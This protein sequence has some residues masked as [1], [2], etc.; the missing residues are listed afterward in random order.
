M[1]HG[2]QLATWR[3]V[4]ALG[5]RAIR[6]LPGGAGLLVLLLGSV[7][8]R[9]QQQRQ[10]PVLF[11]E[12]AAARSVAARSVL[13]ASLR[14]ARPLTID[15]MGVQAA[16]ATAPREGRGGAPLLFAL[17]LPDGSTGNFRVV[18][19]PVM[20]PGL[21]AQFPS[22]KTYSGVGVDDP[23]ASVR[24]DVTPRGFHAQVLSAHGTVYIDP[25]SQTD[26]QHYLSFYHKDMQR[27][28]F[29]CGVS[30]A[31]AAQRTAAGMASPV[32]RTVG[33]TLRTFRL[34]MAATGEYTAF[35][36]GTVALGQ[37]A[38][39]TTVNRV[40]GVYERELAVRMVLVANNSQL[41]YTNASTDP[42]SNTSSDLN[43]ITTSI[44]NVI[45]AANYDIGHLVGTG[46]GGV[47]GLGVV[48]GSSKGRGLTGSPS[49]VGDAF[50]IDYVAHEIGHQF[51]GNHTF[52]SPT[53]NCAGNR[54]ANTAYEPGSGST[55]MA[56]AGICGSDDL[57]PNSDPFFHVVSFEEISA[58]VSTVTC[59]T[60]TTTGNTPPVIASLPVSG[61]VIPISTPFKLTAGATDADGDALTYN[62]EEYDLGPSGT[63]TAAQVA[64]Q[65]PP[66]F[67]SFAPTT[68][69]TRYFPRLSNLLTNTLP[70][71][72]R[73]PTVTRNLNFRVTVRDN[74]KGVNSSSTV[75]MSTTNSAGPFVVLSPNAAVSWVSLSNQTVTW[76]VS[77]T[78]TAPVS[79]A[80]VNIR[81]STDGGLTYPTVLATNTQNDG[82]EVITV[83]NLATTT[84]R[85][86][87]EAADNYF[88][89][90][91]NTNFTITATAVPVAVTA[92]NRAGSNPSN[93]AVVGFTVTFSGNVTGLS[94]ANFALAT[95][96]GVSGASISSVSGSGASYVVAVNTGTGSGTLGL[97]LSNSAGL[98]PS[99]STPLPFVGQTYIIDKA[100]PVVT[101]VAVPA[102]GTYTTGQALDFL[103]NF[104]EAAFVTTSGGL[105]T[106]GV[107]VGAT[108]RQTQYVSGSG[109]TALTFRYTV[110]AGE[111]DTDGIAVGTLA[112][113]GGT[114]RDA[115][116]NDA[117]L[118]LA[119][120]AATAGVLV[121][122]VNPSVTIS[123]PASPTTATSPIPFSV[124]FS[125]PVT[126]FVATDVSVTNGTVSS[127]G[128]TGSSYT[129][130]VTPTA[131]GPVTVS[132]AAGVAQDAAGNGNSA[133]TPVTRVYAPVATVANVRVL[134]QNDEPG[135]PGN[136][137]VRPNLQL[138]NDGTA[139]IPYA[140]LTMRYWLT[141]ENFAALTTS[142]NWA[143]LGT[144]L[145][146]ARYVPLAA[147]LQGAMG[148]VEYS[149]LPGAG[150]LLPNTGSGPILSSFN[151]SNWTNFDETDDYSYAPNS[152][153]QPTTRITVYR[154]GTLIGGVEP[155][156]PAP[157]SLKVYA[158]NQTTSASAQVITT[159]AQIGNLSGL[160][161]SYAGLTV[162]YWFTPDGPSP[163]VGNVDYAQLGS[164][165]I[166]LTIGQQG[167]QS[168][169]ELRFAASLGSLAPGSTTGD[170][171]FRLNMVN[172]TNFNQANDHSYRP[173]APL[174]EHPQM[175][176]YQSGVLVY[177]TE[178]AG[179]RAIAA[180]PAPAPAP[181]SGTALTTAL[182][183][184][185]NPFSSSVQ[186]DFSL[187][188][189]GK[190][191]LGVYNA[192]GRLV[193]KLEAGTAT[194][195]E[196]HHV[197]WEAA[198]H[199]SGL[200]LVRLTTEAGV[201]QM[202][203]VKQ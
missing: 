101:S 116:G 43:S 104:N 136:N 29:I 44:N 15:A 172:W 102:N 4:R 108:T 151:K 70:T 48:C 6:L 165:N 72:E 12:D 203:L 26:Q 156:A 138:L 135:Q 42:Y 65:S 36:G 99:I 97:N 132:I 182:E 118:T 93:S 30:E 148:Y 201:H 174:A 190:Y 19:S 178:P 128:G 3:R 193:E 68:S 109:S 88:F 54:N 13:A 162:R 92:I 49:P 103:V 199:A 55:I 39:V 125:E 159:V 175:T 173:A 130:S 58:F 17:P 166:T 176:I 53:G 146:Q 184:Y 11:Q 24:L 23:T 153:Y 181:T 59:G 129:L 195:G 170:I 113:N 106:L 145:V 60:T 139:A 52:N 28:P 169:A 41:V 110:A 179:A 18:E 84:A 35:H 10:V 33:T 87:V 9:A 158:E 51:A 126:G 157:A 27:Q 95:T 69:P 150:N 31:S 8:A 81:L 171:I 164:S 114:I 123:S 45:G 90:I 67:R 75:L 122:A 147:P 50:D 177:G 89:D 14:Q 57:Q 96:G 107:T 191:S 200:Y 78:N 117:T 94:A 124:V 188:L 2:Y 183:S 38:I 100:G 91:S 120:V 21:A 46:G 56:Y 198:N 119:N 62:W 185:P 61:K 144:S 131:P 180:R 194:A 187:S 85:I 7:G 20:E 202:K 134:Y 66:I 111:L 82:S 196:L 127:F 192:Q 16:L 149:F 155:L 189:A 5:G 141:V 32:Q 163:V 115:L 105:P 140:E 79:C 143:A 154:N 73:L 168:Y 37:A 137:V 40:V 152:I 63:L 76:D 133:A 77:G 86:M 197:K 98:S 25:V 121:D 112:L 186:L 161:A 1:E 22:I 34:A 83:P 47:A 64:N 71:G 74:Q 167:T 80:N 160:P 142:V